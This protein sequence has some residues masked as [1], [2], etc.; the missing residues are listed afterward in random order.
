MDENVR[1]EIIHRCQC[2]QSHREVARLLH[3]SRNTIKHVIGEL[4][5]ARLGQNGAPPATESRK[6]KESLLDA[7]E[8]SIKALLVRY[9]NVTVVDLLSRLR[10]RGYRGSYTVLR[11]RVKRLRTLMHEEQWPAPASPG[12]CA[13]VEYRECDLDLERRSADRVYLFSYVLSFSGRRY[14]RLTSNRDLLTTLHEHVHAFQLLQGAAVTAE[15][16]SVPYLIDRFEMGVPVFNATFL[17]FASHHAFRPRLAAGP[18]S[19]EARPDEAFFS[20]LFAELLCAA[21]FRSLDHANERLARWLAEVADMLPHRGACPVDTHREEV[22]H[23]V[24]LPSH[25]WCG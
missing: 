24:P 14:L 9:P 11:D 22:S 5:R 19:H 8:E 17:R 10:E 1:N 4:E 2:G 16:S 25:P 6:R 15:Y 7:H 13:R 23:L 20:R 18:P 21:T 12:A 3:V